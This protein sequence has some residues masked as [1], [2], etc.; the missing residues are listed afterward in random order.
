[1]ILYFFLWQFIL[2]MIS[3]RHIE[4]INSSLK[5]NFLKE[6]VLGSHQNWGES[7]EISCVFPAPTHA[8]PPIIYIP[9]QS[10]NLLEMV[11]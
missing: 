7:T 2:Y 5:K 9:H 10:Y 11:R 6:A 3:Y 8:L 4:L 1:M